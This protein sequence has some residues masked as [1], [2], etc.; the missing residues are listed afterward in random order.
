M[1][2]T[3]QQENSFIDQFRNGS[4][5]AFKS[6]FGQFSKPLRFFAEAII[7]DHQEAE[8]IVVETFLKLY[9]LKENFN[10]VRAIKSFLYLTTRNHCLDFLKYSKRT[11]SR[12]KEMQYLSGQAERP[13]YEVLIEAEFIRQVYIV[14][15]TLP[16]ECKKII[17]M[18]FLEGLGNKEIAEKLGLSVSSVKNQKVRGLHLIRIRLNLIEAFIILFLVWH[19][20]PINCINTVFS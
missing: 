9:K 4:E 1:M 19:V 17:K 10:D 7:K 5:S 15:E 18:A 11:E 3:K 6:I 16:K 12:Y 14:L 8:D 13:I 2:V 20:T